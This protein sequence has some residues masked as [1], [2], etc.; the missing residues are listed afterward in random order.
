MLS[1]QKVGPK[2]KRLIIPWSQFMGFQQGSVTPA[3]SV[4]APV[5]TGSALAAHRHVLHFQ[6]GAAAN[7]VT[8]ATDQLRTAAA[9]FDVAGVANSAGEGGVVDVSGGTPAG[10]NS[11]PAFTGTQIAADTLLQ[12]A[13]AG[14]PLIKELSNFG[15]SGVRMNTAG[16]DMRHLMP[17]PQ[18]WSRN[19]PVNVRM[20]WS[21]EAAAVGNR[22]ITWKFLYGLLIPGTTAIAAPATA[23]DTVI[24]PQ[25]PVGV[26][27]TLE[28]GNKGVINPSALGFNENA[29]LSFLCENDAFH[30]DF[31]E[32]KVF[33]AVEFEYTPNYVG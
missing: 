17:V 33:H 23:L 9:A 11:A 25:A 21:S 10:T 7:A 18:D 16:D 26:A 1:G 32:N 19:H 3:G 12:S 22:T 29:W 4:A 15:I 31:S 5:F 6:T 24:T 30:V 28:R 8:A 14:T 13:G 20:I 2:T 27:H